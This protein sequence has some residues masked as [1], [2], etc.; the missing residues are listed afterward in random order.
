MKHQ[1]SDREKYDILTIIQST[2]ASLDGLNKTG[3]FERHKRL[4]REYSKKFDVVVYS[5][6]TTDYSEE[7]GVEHR[8]IPWLLEGFGL[9][10]AVYYLWLVL[11][12]RKMKGVIK[13][14]GSSIST[15]SLARILS[16]RKTMVTYQ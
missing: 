6:D 10:Y 7:L 16:D 3:I 11:Q 12:A 8:P 13:V 9:R 5:R 1:L 4:L 15:F 2:H 14:F